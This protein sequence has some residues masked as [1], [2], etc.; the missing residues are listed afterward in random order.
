MYRIFF[1]TIYYCSPPP[2][3]LAQAQIKKF[4]SEGWNLTFLHP[5]DHIPKVGHQM[6][7]A[8]LNYLCIDAVH[9]HPKENEPSK[10]YIFMG[11]DVL[12]QPHVCKL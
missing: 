6:G 5:D 10:G 12:F 8:Q 4:V 7:W 9:R 1:K 11:Q 3:K 2:D